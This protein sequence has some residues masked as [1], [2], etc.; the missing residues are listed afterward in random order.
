MRTVLVFVEGNHDV[1]FAT[2][3]LGA[4]GAEWVDDPI[5]KLPAPFGPR[6][7]PPNP[8]SIIATHYGQRRRESLRLAGAAHAPIPVFAAMLK[9]DNTLFVILRAGGDS[10][11]P[12]AQKLL[13][14][15]YDQVAF[16][17]NTPDPLPIT[18][19]AAAFIFDANA[20]GL[21]AR[22]AAFASDY[23]NILPSGAKVEHNQWAKG[24]PRGPVGLFVFHDPAT[25]RGTLDS[26][27]ADMVKDEWPKRWAAA[28]TYLQEH[29]QASDRI[30][31]NDSERHKAQITITGQFLRPGAPMSEVLGRHGLPRK[32]F[33]SSPVSQA[34]GEFLSA[35]PW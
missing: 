22:K 13:G 17:K 20:A 8:T 10:A 33:R 34:V 25:K 29:T 3:S 27:L 32:C 4:I 12:H 23:A 16:F 35:V 2:R 21:D 30:T 6:G 5:D 18:D 26:T 28:G 7:K 9:F 19:V 31:K 14:K 15:I 24:G 1:V 11:A